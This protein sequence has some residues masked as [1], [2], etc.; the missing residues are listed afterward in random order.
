MNREDNHLLTPEPMEDFVETEYVREIT[1]RAL[2]YIA[3]GFPV[4]F[5]GPAGTGKTTIAKHIAAKLEKPMVLIHGD[6][7]LSTT[8]LIGG[9]FGFQSKKVIDN[10]ISSVLKKEEN[11]VKHWVDNRLTVACRYGFTLLYDEFSRSRPEANNILLS[12][13][14]DKILN[15]PIA[16]GGED[17][18]LK[19]H[20]DFTAI[21]TSNPEEYAGVYKTQDALKDRMITIDLDYF[22]EQT[23]LNITQAK[24]KIDQEKAQLIVNIIRRLRQL[25]QYRFSPTVRSCIMIARSIQIMNVDPIEDHQRFSKICQD[26]LISDGQYEDPGMLYYN[27]QQVLREVVSQ[28]IAEQTK[29][30]MASANGKISTISDIKESISE[31]ESELSLD[32]LSELL[33]DIKHKTGSEAEVEFGNRN[34]NAE[35]SPLKVVITPQ[36]QTTTKDATLIAEKENKAENTETEEEVSSEDSNKRREA[37]L[38]Q[39]EERISRLR[40]FAQNRNIS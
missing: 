26:V 40:S 30:Y 25:E 19:V 1:E 33:E 39:A 16:R 4:H 6:E 15:L 20:P 35:T 18:Y 11:F 14:E 32:S 27:K 24:A 9:E 21:F 12:I 23:E 8:T 22:D 13:L 36:N 38:K 31:A 10:F 5:R 3:A 7:E 34:G 37:F 17:P 28:V 29:S 2:G